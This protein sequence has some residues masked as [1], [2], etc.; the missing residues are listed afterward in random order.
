MQT[1]RYPRATAFS[2]RPV[3]LPLLYHGQPAAE[4][5]TEGR[6]RTGGVAP[7]L[8][9][10]Q[11]HSPAPVWGQPIKPRL[12][13]RAIR[14][15][16]LPEGAQTD[17]QIAGDLRD[18][19]AFLHAELDRQRAGIRRNTGYAHPHPHRGQVPVVS[20]NSQSASRLIFPPARSGHRAGGVSPR[21]SLARCL[22][23]MPTHSC[24]AG[25][26]S[27]QAMY[28]FQDSMACKT[29]TFS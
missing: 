25:A 26:C 29:F 9:C 13:L 21:R 3:R 6:Q 27:A 19:G 14:V 2:G 23:A 17:P 1:H 24:S 16:P 28:R 18:G 20:D 4:A 5:A 7:I 8:L 22:R 15:N 11:R 12:A 10:R